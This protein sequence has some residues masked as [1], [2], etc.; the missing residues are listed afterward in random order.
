[1]TG[2]NFSS[3]TLVNLTLRS[4]GAWETFKNYA[5]KTK[6]LIKTIKTTYYENKLDQPKDKSK[7]LFQLDKEIDGNHTNQRV[8]FSPD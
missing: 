4:Q 6:V 1:M 3:K 7:N 5:K 2:N 8:K